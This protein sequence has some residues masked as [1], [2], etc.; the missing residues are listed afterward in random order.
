M[1]ALS[2]ILLFIASAAGQ[3]PAAPP[4]SA[5]PEAE[6][7]TWLWV[8][9]GV[10]AAVLVLAGAC[11]FIPSLRKPFTSA[12]GMTA[13]TG[14]SAGTSNH[15]PVLAMATTATYKLGNNDQSA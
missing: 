11:F 6:D 9:I 7:L 3:T 2:Y 10:L 13:A 14:A 15:M 12:L 4:P 5:P 1:K 8:L